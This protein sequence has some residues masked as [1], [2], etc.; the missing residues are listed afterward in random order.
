MPDPSRPLRA[1]A[2]RNRERVLAAAEVVLA[3]DGMSAS[4]RE[5]ARQAGVG[6]ATIYRQFPTKEA[7]YE[8][9]VIGRVRRLVDQAAALSAA[10]DAGAAFFGF[11]TSIVADATHKK[12][13]V[14]ALADAGV[15]VK[16]RMGDLQRAMVDA[17][18]TLLDRARRAG[19]V[20][21]DLAMPELLALLAAA[22]LAAERNQW[23]ESLRTRALA[24]MFDGFRPR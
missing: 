9:I 11:F 23:D 14:D 6:L 22:C 3:R 1:D 19:A 17:I 16:A 12:V 8:E 10:E 18:E 24:I 15:D 7:L 20:R 13:L 2:R 4:L 21:G 5:I